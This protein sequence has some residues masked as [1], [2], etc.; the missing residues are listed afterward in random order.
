MRNEYYF[1]VQWTFK[2]IPYDL[3]S[4]GPY[5]SRII[6]DSPKL[7]IRYD[8]MSKVVVIQFDTKEESDKYWE[9]NNK[10]G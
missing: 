5:H 3:A 2:S 6:T 8:D 10:D 4:S 1:Y 7:D 9:E